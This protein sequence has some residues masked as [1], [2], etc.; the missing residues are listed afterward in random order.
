MTDPTSEDTPGGFLRPILDDWLPWLYYDSKLWTCVGFAGALVFGS[1]FLLQWLQ[2]EKEKRLV[3]PWYFWHLSFW[4][5]CLNFIYF[6]HLDKAPLILG[7][8]FLP[9][10]YGRNLILLYRSKER[11]LRGGGRS[12]EKEDQDSREL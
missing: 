3:V 11:T 10:L 4:G 5:S 1:R 2:S 12:D 6:I 9:V 8:C 7:N